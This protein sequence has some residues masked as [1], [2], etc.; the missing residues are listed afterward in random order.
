MICID[1]G[2]EYEG[3]FCPKCGQPAKTGRITVKDTLHSV[4]TSFL[5]G[6]NK[7]INT[8]WQLIIRPGVMVRNY[9]YG[10]RSKLMAPVPLL[11]RMVAV[12]LLVKF[13]FDIPS[14]E[15]HFISDDIQGNIHSDSL[16]MF[17]GFM[18]HVLNNNVLFALMSAA[19]FVLPFYLLY[20][21]K[22]IERPG[23]A[24]LSL[25]TAEHF[26]TLVYVGCMYMMLSFL[27]LPFHGPEHMGI[28]SVADFVRLM[29]P[30]IVYHQLYRVGWW[31]SFWRCIVAWIMV[32]VALIVFVL[33]TFGLFYGFDAVK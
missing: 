8:C 29:F 1:C 33:L 4:F 28:K 32:I 27:L 10:R 30:V 11:V 22:M 9:L 17:C 3:S 31:A 2:T 25:N 18:E 5:V 21:K 15:T 24:S 6:D 13:L 23:G 26:Y 7:F 16:L 14:G 12:Y 19:L 20:K